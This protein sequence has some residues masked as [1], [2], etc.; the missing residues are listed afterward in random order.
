M[1]ILSLAIWAQ[2]AGIFLRGDLDSGGGKT[3]TGTIEVTGSLGS[4][5]STVPIQSADGALRVVPGLLKGPLPAG[6]IGDIDGDADVDFDDFLFFGEAFGTVAGDPNYNSKADLN[7]D[8][9]IEFDDF[10]IFSEAFGS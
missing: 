4:W 6:V 3:S 1:A 7:S 8:G 10:L 2:E 9:I 5:F